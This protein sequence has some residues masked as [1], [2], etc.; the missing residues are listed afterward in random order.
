M[1]RLDRA[2]AWAIE[3]FKPKDAKEPEYSLQLYPT[4]KEARSMRIEERFSCEAEW[5]QNV[6]IGRVVK[7][8]LQ[9]V[10]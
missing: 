9:E 4:R 1:S 7:V 6:R 3:V 10:T 5:G 2:T 8:Y